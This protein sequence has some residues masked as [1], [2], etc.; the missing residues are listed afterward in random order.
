MVSANFSEVRTRNNCMRV[1]VQNDI[2]EM[3]SFLKEL[4]SNKKNY[5]KN[6]KQTEVNF[7]IVCLAIFKVLS[8]LQLF[9]YFIIWIS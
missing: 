4:L 7:S 3:A 9:R 6:C 1:V 8:Y 2:N 5:Q